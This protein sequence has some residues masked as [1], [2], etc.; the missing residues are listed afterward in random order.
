M[1]KL[2]TFLF[3]KNINIILYAI[4]HDQSF[5]YSL[6]NGIVIFEQLGPGD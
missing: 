5:I 4:F 1:Q 2:L 3:S 6:T